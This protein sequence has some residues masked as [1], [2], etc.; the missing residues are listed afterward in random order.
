MK[1]M[2]L[3]G[4]LVGALVGRVHAAEID[5]AWRVE[6]MQTLGVRGAAKC[7]DKIVSGEEL[8]A[9]CAKFKDFPLVKTL[10]ERRRALAAASD[11]VKAGKVKVGMT[12]EEVRLSW[13]PPDRVHHS[14]AGSTSEEQW[15]YRG[16]VNDPYSTDQYLYFENGRL[17]GW[18]D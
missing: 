4:M 5:E 11:D 9:Q 8:D 14:V 13:G 16:D 7:A 1:R 17:K 10:V 6:F 2:V 15:V 18:Q 3:A 12:A